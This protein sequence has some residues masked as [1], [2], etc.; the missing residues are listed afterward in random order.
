MAVPTGDPA[1]RRKERSRRIQNAWPHRAN[2]IQAELRR[3]LQEY[4]SSSRT[5]GRVQMSLESFQTIHGR[6]LQAEAM[7]RLVQASLRER[8]AM[9]GTSPDS[10]NESKPAD[11]FQASG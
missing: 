11:R 2:T 7:R 5:A 4:G 8:A 1:S 3:E 10:V 9:R 6:V